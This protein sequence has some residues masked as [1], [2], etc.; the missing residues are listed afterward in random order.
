MQDIYGFDM[1]H[2]RINGESFCS[3]EE[4]WR[5]VGCIEPVP[6]LCGEFKNSDF[7]D[8]ANRVVEFFRQL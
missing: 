6:P 1:Q 7:E 2:V 8:N 4:R 5:L 3:I